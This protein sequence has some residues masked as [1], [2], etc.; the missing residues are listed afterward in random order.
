MEIGKKTG[1]RTLL[2]P[3]GACPAVSAQS[4][5]H[6]RKKAVALYVYSTNSTC[7][8]ASPPYPSLSR[9]GQSTN[10]PD[11]V[12]PSFVSMKPEYTSFKTRFDDEKNLGGSTN[13]AG[14]S[15]I[16]S[17]CLFNERSHDAAFAYS[18]AHVVVVFYVYRHCAS[19]V[20]NIR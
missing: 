12:R 8:C 13:E 7:E 6:F 5:S 17:T 11:I 15:C 16:H 20:W 2:L 18:W 14:S 9:F 4:R 3:C 10:I 19:D 1:A